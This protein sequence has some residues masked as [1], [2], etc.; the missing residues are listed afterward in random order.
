METKVQVS[1]ID[2]L[3]L[4]LSIHKTKLSNR[5]AVSVSGDLVKS[6]RAGMFCKPPRRFFGELLD[7]KLELE[8]NISTSSGEG[9]DSSSEDLDIKGVT[10]NSDLSFLASSYCKKIMDYSLGFQ[11]F[12]RI[13]GVSSSTQKKTIRKIQ[14]FLCLMAEQETHFSK[15]S[16]ELMTLTVVLAASEAAL[17]SKE[18]VLAFCCQP[19]DSKQ[20]AVNKL[21]TLKKTK[22]YLMLKRLIN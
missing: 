14:E 11:D 10:L 2:S 8:A 6:L 22:A 20:S 5:F 3:R 13:Q 7:K 1:D 21:A 4:N 17:L 16:A 18:I 9:G 15:V 12:L 19:A